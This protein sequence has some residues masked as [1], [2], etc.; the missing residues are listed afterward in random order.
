MPARIGPG[1]S[2]PLG[3]RA[4]ALNAPG[5]LI[6]ATPDVASIG[7]S[8]SHGCVRMAPGDEQDLF[9]RVGVGTPVVIVTAGPAHPRSAAP[10]MPSSPATPASPTETAAQF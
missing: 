10:A 2:N 8:A 7:Y 5:I 6:H 4:L 1:P 9:G 3:T